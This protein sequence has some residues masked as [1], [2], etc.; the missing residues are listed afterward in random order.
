MRLSY[1]FLPKKTFSIDAISEDRTNL[2][3]T[4]RVLNMGLKIDFDKDQMVILKLITINFSICFGLAN[5]LPTC[6]KI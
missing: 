2:S 6:S 3:L 4:R 5:G 1:C